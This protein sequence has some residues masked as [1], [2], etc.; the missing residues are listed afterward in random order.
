MIEIGYTF[1]NPGLL[2]T[3]LTHT[4]YANEHRTE[5]YERL[6]FLGDA[7]LD[8][9][10]GEMLFL[11]KP[12]IREGDMTR[13]RSE[14]VCED[15]L[16]KA[17]CRMQLSDDLRIGR[18]EEKTGGRHRVSV[19]ADVVEAVLAAIYIDGGFE[20]ARNFAMNYVLT[21]VPVDSNFKGKL[22]EKAQKTGAAEIRYELTGESGPDHSKS[23]S[24]AVFVNGVRL[25]EGCGRTKQEAEQKAAEEALGKWQENR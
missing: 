5:S 12:E 13:I 21:S 9:F 6:E 23:F 11:S 18:G 14:M 7:L 25:G 2:R 3:A 24:S 8:F 22:Q 4:S 19:L 15:S 17:A 1:K 20:E 16:Y 10:A